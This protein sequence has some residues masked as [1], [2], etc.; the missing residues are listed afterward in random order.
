MCMGVCV[1]VKEREKEREREREA[2]WWDGPIY[3]RCV[4]VMCSVLL[5]VFD[6]YQYS[7][8]KYNNVATWV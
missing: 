6:I 7:A 1:R 3:T 8:H 2:E 4:L 5:N